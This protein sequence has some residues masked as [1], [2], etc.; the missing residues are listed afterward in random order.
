VTALVPLI[1]YDKAAQIA[2]HAL[3][4]DLTLRQAALQ[5][6]FVSEVDFDRVVD[7]RA[8]VRPGVAAPV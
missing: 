1:G 6:G 8:M 3:V 2:H 5:L 7:P 4:E